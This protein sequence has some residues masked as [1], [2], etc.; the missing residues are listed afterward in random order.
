MKWSQPADARVVEAVVATFRDSAERSRERLSA[1]SERNWVR[2][3]FWLDASGMALYFVN[4]LEIL[5]I[6][7]AI[8]ATTLERLQ[9]NFAD[10]RIRSAAMFAEFA[11]INQ[12]F[13]AAGV[14][15]ANLKGFSLS[16]ESCPHPALRRQLDF[17]FMIDGN[18]LELCREI[19]IERSYILTAA[20]KTTW[21]FKAGASELGGMKDFYKTSS[22]HSVELHFASSSTTA[23]S[24]S[25][26]ERL[27]RQ[28]VCERV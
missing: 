27:D 5:G 4:Q 25:R 7:D 19:L 12:A 15:Y 18:H 22:R 21:E 14:D 8:P 28:Q 3:Y 24:P 20:S 1:I 23:P 2:S 11:S 9:Q 6:E 16:P 26:D 17:D 10:N 13:Q